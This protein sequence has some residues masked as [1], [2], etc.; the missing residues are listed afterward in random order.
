MARVVSVK[1]TGEIREKIL[2]AIEKA[3]SKSSLGRVLG[4]SGNAADI[5]RF[6]SLEYGSQTIPLW[7][8][9]KLERFLKDNRSQKNP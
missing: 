4:Y 8:L 1:I 9:E 7:R 2:R 6:L 5:N 3:G